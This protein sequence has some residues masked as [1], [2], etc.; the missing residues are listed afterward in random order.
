MMKGRTRWI[1]W[2]LFPLTAA[3]IAGS[4]ARC[5][6]DSDDDDFGD[7]FDKVVVEEA[8]AGRPNLELFTG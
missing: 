2:F 8:D 7:I 1:A 5:Q 6:F 4:D 3:L